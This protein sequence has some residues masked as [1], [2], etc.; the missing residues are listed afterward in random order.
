MVSH[1]QSTNKAYVRLKLREL[2]L[3]YNEQYHCLSEVLQVSYTDK[4][5]ATASEFLQNVT[6]ENLLLTCFFS[7]FCLQVQVQ[8]M[9]GNIQFDTYGR[10]TNYTI[11]VYEMKASGSRKVSFKIYIQISYL[12]K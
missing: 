3:F 8:G 9:T 11:D 12:W 10:R 1:Q 4:N 7:T 5:C 2:G 6:E